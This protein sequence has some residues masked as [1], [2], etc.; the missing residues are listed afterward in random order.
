MLVFN[1]GNVYQEVAAGGRWGRGLIW[2][3]HIW[4][5][6]CCTISILQSAPAFCS[7]AICISLLEKPG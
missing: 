3:F 7:A 4:N 6:L 5:F 2:D 1:A